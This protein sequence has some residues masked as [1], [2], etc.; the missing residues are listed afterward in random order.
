MTR[1]FHYRTSVRP[2]WID[3]NGHMQDAYYGLVFS[4][5]VDAFQDEVGFDAA[6]RKATGCTT[7]YPLKVRRPP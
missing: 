6:Y 5:A 2:E 3:Y 7:Y 1:T 4:H